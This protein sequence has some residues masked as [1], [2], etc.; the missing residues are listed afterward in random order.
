MDPVTTLGRRRCCE[1]AFHVCMRVFMTARPRYNCP[2]AATVVAAAASVLW[3]LDRVTFRFVLARVVPCVRFT[4][5]ETV[6]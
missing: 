3:A 6:I 4:A 1:C 5:H 2:R